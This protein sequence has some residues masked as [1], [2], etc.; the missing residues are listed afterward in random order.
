MNNN[1]K[2]VLRKFRTLRTL[3]YWIQFNAFRRSI[4]KNVQLENN[5]SLYSMK[6]NDR[7]E[8]FI[9]GN[10]PSLTVDDLSRI[11][12]K[13]SFAS[14]GIYKV[15]D[16]SDWRPTY[17]F[18]QDS[19]AV[20]QVF[21]N[22]QDIIDDVEAMFISMNFY[23]DFPDKIK[24]SD[25]TRILYIRFKP[26]KNGLYCFSDDVTKE[27]FEG[28]SVT[29]SMLQM[30]LYMGFKRIYLLGV[31]HSFNLEIDRDGKII[32]RSDNQI[33][34]FYSELHKNEKGHPTKIDEI[35]KAYCSAEK[36]SKQKNAKIFNATR[37]GKLE[38][39]ER[40]DFDK[41]EI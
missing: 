41:L 6:G 12:N 25:K 36:Y 24:N 10:G 4:P 5:K 35:T 13:I 34:H 3:Y 32:K 14:N 29:Y 16:L 11:K 38:V 31:D 2:A 33:N 8:C 21:Q 1:I 15:F 37:G 18:I 28:L 27:V 20:E 26:P 30:A 40:I 23:N 7:E 17:Y 19:I 39:F 9:I 22:H